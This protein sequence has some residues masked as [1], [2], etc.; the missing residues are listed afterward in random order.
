[1]NFRASISSIR[2]SICRSR[3]PTA[4]AGLVFSALYVPNGWL[5]QFLAPLG[6]E[7]AYTRLG[8]VIILVSIGFPFVVRTVQPVLESLDAEWKKPLLVSGPAAGKSF[9]DFAA[10]HLPG[11][12]T[13]FAYRSRALGRIR[14]RHLRFGEHALQDGNRSGAYCR[15][16]RRFDYAEAT[17]IAVVLLAA[18]FVMLVVIN[19]LERWSKVDR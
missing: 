4:V 8:I 18:S 19:L 2:W 15:Q 1:M 5:G 12:I 3:L 6:I 13:G 10:C 16:A 9:G 7:V 14:F 17:A 11:L